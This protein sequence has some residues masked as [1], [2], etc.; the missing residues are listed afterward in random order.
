MQPGAGYQAVTKWGHSPGNGAEATKPSACPPAG[1]PSSSWSLQLW[2][3]PPTHPHQR[4]EL[5]RRAQDHHVHIC[6]PY[7]QQG[8]S[9]AAPSAVPGLT[10]VVEARDSARPSGQSGRSVLWAQNQQKQ[11][12]GSRLLRAEAPISL[13]R[14][15]CA[16]FSAD[17]STSFAVSQKE[18]LP[19]HWK[20][21][22]ISTLGPKTHSCCE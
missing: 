7:F 19:H 18:G 6:P 14:S 10:L 21:S 11:G 2:P 4:S 15:C 17:P 1:I 13:P 8:L 5:G 3:A 9:G 20:S 12:Q 22:L 16:F